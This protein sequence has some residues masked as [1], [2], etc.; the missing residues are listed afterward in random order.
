MRKSATPPSPSWRKPSPSLLTKQT[1]LLALGECDIDLSST[2][3][4]LSELARATSESSSAGVWNTAAY[5]LA[6]R[7]L[8]L[9]RAQK[10]AET[11]ITVESSRL[12]DVSLD[13]LS[14]AQL[15]RVDSIGSY[16]DTLGWI[17]FRRGNNDQA[18]TYTQAAWSLR[19]LPVIA[20]HLGQIYEALGKHDDAKH[21]YALTVA[22]SDSPV[23]LPLNPDESDALDDARERLSKSEP[24][25]KAVGK[26]VDRAR[27]DIVAMHQVSIPNA[28]KT[29]GSADFTLNAI[30]PGKASQVRQ[31]SGDSSFASFA[32]ILQSATLPMQFPD[33]SAI[34]IPRR[35]TLICTGDE[36]QC[37]F[38]LLSADDA[39]DLSRKESANDTAAL[40]ANP[41]DPHT[42]N[43]PAIG[44]KVS[45]PDDWQ[46]VHEERGS[47]SHPR[48]AMLGK[49]GT[50][51][52]LL[53]T[54]ERL[55]GSADLYQK[56]IEAGFLQR[57]EYRRT[58]EMEVKRDGISGTH[59]NISWKEK[60]VTYTA[61][62]EFF[63]DGDDHYRIT[64]MSPSEVYSRYSENFEDMLRSVRFPMLHND[65]NL[66]DKP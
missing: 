50:V 1:S 27:T 28:K 48:S 20:D 47:Y 15:S 61:V 14:T 51:A 59:W 52:S 4:G 7:N 17:Y 18:L 8:E 22:A 25:Q 31:V 37:Q 36:S 29:T 58:V 62:M 57:E 60:G 3:K 24:S 34:E 26:L 33:A 12:H 16:W 5:A 66:L 56:M 38:Q 64:A 30:P 10:W 9:E 63:S 21:A 53:L 45:L 13:H 46:L 11:A 32:N 40:T 42:Y 2:A 55:E 19:P 49:P 39:I 41:I 43:N 54:R 44:I 23:I 65:P 35:G 6:R